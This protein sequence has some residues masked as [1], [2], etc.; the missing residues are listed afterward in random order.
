[1]SHDRQVSLALHT[2]G[3]HTSDSPVHFTLRRRTTG[4]ASD[5]AVGRTVLCDN[6]HAREA[7][8][9]AFDHVASEH[10]ARSAAR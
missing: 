6:L 2:H 5:P 10:D 8:V 3:L 1:M 9:Q 4:E 7:R